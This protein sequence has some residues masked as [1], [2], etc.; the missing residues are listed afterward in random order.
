MVDN[1][2][3]LEGD[4]D[5]TEHISVTATRGVEVLPTSYH[6]HKSKSQQVQEELNDSEEDATTESQGI[7]YK[8]FLELY[9]DRML[10]E[11][12]QEMGIGKN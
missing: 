8:K 3:A 4:F 2:D 6:K 9:R 11:E 7:D 5:N 1:K 12:I 10:D